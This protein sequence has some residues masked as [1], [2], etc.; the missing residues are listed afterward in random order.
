M[1]TFHMIPLLILLTTTH[2][3]ERLGRISYRQIQR[4]NGGLL[5]DLVMILNRTIR[6]QPE[7]FLSK[8][9]N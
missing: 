7:F 8:C 2:S 3:Q 1:E 5:E 9:Q 4:S 6:A